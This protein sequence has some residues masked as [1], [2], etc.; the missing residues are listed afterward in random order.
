M[1]LSGAIG[2]G[3]DVCNDIEA[4][5]SSIHTGP[6]GVVASVVDGSPN[7]DG[8]TR[9]RLA[10]AYTDGSF[11]LEVGALLGNHNVQSS[12]VTVA[13][14]VV[15]DPVGFVSNLPVKVDASVEV[16]GSGFEV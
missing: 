13:P 14:G 5:R 4:N 10:A 3:A 6:S 7:V 11:E 9:K 16:P 12:R 8:L 15:V 1:D 2:S